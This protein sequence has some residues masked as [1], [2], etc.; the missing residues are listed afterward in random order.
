MTQPRLS[1]VF[2]YSDLRL[3][4]DGTRVYQKSTN[5]R[6]QI[7]KVA[8]QTSRNNWI[9]RDAGGL[10]KTPKFR[11]KIKETSQDS[12][13]E[14]EFVRVETETHSPKP[15]DEG[16]KK[17][18][19]KRFDGRKAKRQEFLEN[20]DYLNR[21]ASTSSNLASEAGTKY[22]PDEPS[23][24]LLKCIHRYASEYYTQSGQLLNSSR[25]YRKQRKIRRDIKKAQGRTKISISP[26]NSRTPSPNHDSLGSES[27]I[28]TRDGDYDNEGGS[29]LDKGKE[30]EKAPRK[31]RQR[32]AKQYRDMY[33][34]FDGSAIMA[35][36]MLIQEYIVDVLDPQPSGEWEEEM[37]KAFTTGHTSEDE[38]EGD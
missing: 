31:G 1:T 6:P 24:D 38:D 4:P 29:K 19:T 32:T 28:S 36:G 23:S 33:K 20:Y 2:D 37:R 11:K 30:K 18:K 9:A 16:R 25:E 27:D 21:D 26:T 12:Q 3:H 10:A 34:V 7:T 5:L 22:V 8:V 14:E 35:I 15:K 17:R 13:G